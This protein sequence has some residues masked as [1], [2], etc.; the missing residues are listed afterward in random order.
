MVNNYVAPKHLDAFNQN[1][2]YCLRDFIAL[3]EE[4]SITYFACGGTAIGAVRHKGFI[5]WDDDMDVYML[6]DDY[7]KFLSLKSSLVGSKYEIVDMFDEGYCKSFA[8][9]S[10]A[11]TTVWEY[12]ET[13]FILGAYIDVFPLDAALDDLESLKSVNYRYEQLLDWYVRSFRP[14]QKLSFA[15]IGELKSSLVNIFLPMLRKYIKKQLV[16]VEREITTF[17][18]KSLFGY[19]YSPRVE[20]EIFDRAWFESTVELDFE[21]LKIKLP[22]GYHEMLTKQYGD[23]MQLPPIEEQKTHHSRYFVD[24]TKRLT[25]EEVQAML[26]K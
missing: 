9:F 3:C 11:H 7:N 18:G 22:V 24:L 1:L 6:R 2:C 26:N 10:D 23:Y 20:R 13:P 17:Q 19:G 21:G 12:E 16:R 4:H 15:S 14:T 8:K 5:P 25:L